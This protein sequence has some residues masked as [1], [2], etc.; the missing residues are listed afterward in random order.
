LGQV[1]KLYLQSL[2]PTRELPQPEHPF[3]LKRNIP[4][5]QPFLDLLLSGSDLKGRGFKEEE[6]R[7][8]R[9]GKSLAA[10]RF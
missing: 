9:G 7:E 4:S 8:Y 5:H 2:G 6:S 3:S 1:R 10:L